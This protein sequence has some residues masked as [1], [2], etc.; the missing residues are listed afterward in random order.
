MSFASYP[1]LCSCFWCASQCISKKSKH[2][3]TTKRKTWRTLR[4]L[5]RTRCA[6]GTRLLNR[7]LHM[8][9][10][11]SGTIQLSSKAVLKAN[12]N[13][14]FWIVQKASLRLRAN[15]TYEICAYASW[16]TKMTY[17]VQ[18]KNIEK[19]KNCHYSS[20][21]TMYNLKQWTS[22]AP[23]AWPSE[24]A[25]TVVHCRS[26]KR[27][28]TDIKSAKHDVHESCSSELFKTCYKKIS[29][30]EPCNYAKVASCK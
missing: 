16:N 23:L 7:T 28:R 1:M 24:L 11:C 10:D 25:A 14:V 15:I 19:A 9:Q 18:N 3:A 2:P 4:C 29:Q 12:S 26:R 17:L 30:F 27:C 6:W 13:N 20:L 8:F 22:M 21:K 5:V